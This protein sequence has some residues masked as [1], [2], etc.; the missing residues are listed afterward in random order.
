MIVKYNHFIKNADGM[1]PFGSA[2]MISWEP[3][4]GKKQIKENVNT[5]IS[6]V[7][8]NENTKGIILHNFTKKNLGEV[9]ELAV[10]ADKSGLQVMFW[11]DYDSLKKFHE[12]I[13]GYYKNGLKH[14]F[15]TTNEYD[16]A[17][18][19]R[20][21]IDT[22]IDKTYYVKVGK[23]DKSLHS[24]EYENFG[25]YLSSTN[26]IIFEIKNEG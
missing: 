14:L 5:L 6:R 15:V 7:L 8:S 18:I 19:G 25:V 26:Q 22:A 21:I 9:F 16:Y 2:T 12:D 20:L 23:Y 1:C 3:S 17:Q 4:L 24:D 11:T 13:G 10:E